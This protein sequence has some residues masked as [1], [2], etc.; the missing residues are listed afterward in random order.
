[1]SGFT[2]G[3]RWAYELTDTKAHYWHRDHERGEADR[4]WCRQP[5]SLHALYERVLKPRGFELVTGGAS[6]LGLNG[7]GLDERSTDV[8]YAAIHG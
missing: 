6:W 8:L 2:R 5:G 7:P 3:K 1:M 4:C